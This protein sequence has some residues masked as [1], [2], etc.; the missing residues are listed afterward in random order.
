MP[1]VI[2][3]WVLHFVYLLQK[4]L[5]LCRPTTSQT[6]CRPCILVYLFKAFVA[7]KIGIFF[8]VCVESKF[9]YEIKF[10][11]N[12]SFVNTVYVVSC[13]SCSTLVVIVRC[14]INKNAVPLHTFI[15][16]YTTLTLHLFFGQIQLPERFFVSRVKFELW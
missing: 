11:L 8:C 2:K 12:L 3:V 9:N 6:E 13:N 4:Y 15:F 14:A 5:F 7:G 10:L 1:L 16:Q